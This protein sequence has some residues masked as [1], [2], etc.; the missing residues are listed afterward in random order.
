MCGDLNFVGLQGLIK[1]SKILQIRNEN[2]TVR[3]FHESES[4]RMNQTGAVLLPPA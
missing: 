4:N 2:V 3:R 1:F